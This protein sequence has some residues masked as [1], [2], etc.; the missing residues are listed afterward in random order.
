MRKSLNFCIPGMH[1]NEI[2]YDFSFIYA[3]STYA[4]SINVN[5]SVKQGYTE[6]TYITIN[7]LSS[8]YLSTDVLSIV[9]LTREIEMYEGGLGCAKTQVVN[10]QL[11]T[12]APEV[13]SQ[14]RSSAICGTQSGNDVSFLLIL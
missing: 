1:P 4:I 6:Y 8:Q 9:Y 12:T 11:P 7:I 5:S 14:V 13:R 10:H 2:H 3:D